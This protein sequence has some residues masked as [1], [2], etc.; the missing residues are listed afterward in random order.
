MERIISGKIIAFLEEKDLFSTRE[1]LSHT[2]STALYLGVGAVTRTFK[3]G[4]NTYI[5][6]PKPLTK[7]NHDMICQELH[8]FRILK[9]LESGYM[10]FRKAEIRQWWPLVLPQRKH[11]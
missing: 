10:T 2:A 4:R 5:D 8:K 3:C 9:K 6:L 7:I 1:E 11:K